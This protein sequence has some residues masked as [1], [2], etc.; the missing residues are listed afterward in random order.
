MGERVRA[1]VT[2][3]TLSQRLG[4]WLAVSLAGGLATF[5]CLF[6]VINSG[7]LPLASYVGSRYDRAAH[8][9]QVYVTQNQI[10]STD[11]NK[12]LAWAKAKGDVG[13]G[14][15]YAEGP[16]DTNQDQS[17]SG[18]A[19]QG[20]LPDGPVEVDVTADYLGEDQSPAADYDNDHYY[21]MY[22]SDQQAI[23]YLYGS[24]GASLLRAL[25]VV[26]GVVSIVVMF[27]IFLTGIRNRIRYIR[28]LE[29]EIAAMGGGDLQTPV[30]VEG[31]DELGRLAA[32]LEELRVTLASQIAAEE[33]A[34]QANRD[35]VTAL[36]HDLRTPLTSLLLYTQI[37]QDG[38]YRD[39]AE[40]HAYLDRIHV[41][42]THMKALSDELLHHFLVAEEPAPE[43][44]VVEEVPLGLVLGDLVAS[45]ASALEAAGFSFEVEGDLS[46]EDTP[47]EAGKV[48]RVFNN[49]FSNVLKYGD[50]DRPV[51]MGCSSGASSCLVRVENAVREG[52]APSAEAGIGL[53]SVRSLMGELGGTVR[54]ARVGSSFAVELEFVRKGCA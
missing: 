38:K 17:V 1:A 8:E 53:R 15:I 2:G 11:T 33:R 30:N 47:V 29:G 48:E 27:A 31:D 20:D 39:E 12:L 14:V 50:K 45:F 24:Y 26:A 44:A 9:L 37:L 35:L 32:Q 19:S 4:K 23:V 18:E 13:L 34:Q 40:L 49:L 28:D 42:A 25:D 6:A 52:T 43:E 21:R 7:A 54:V 46:G 36:S 16:A 3:G 51:T 41:G 22:F 5:F 10:A